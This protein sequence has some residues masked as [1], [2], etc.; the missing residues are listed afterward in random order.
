MDD[1]TPYIRIV[2]VT[3]IA[4]RHL[5]IKSLKVYRLNS[6]YILQSFIFL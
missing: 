3:I 4:S 5:M 2:I 6:V 1:L